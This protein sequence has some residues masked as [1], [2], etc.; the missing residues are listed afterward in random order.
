[1]RLCPDHAES[2][3]SNSQR[4]HLG[5][6]KISKSHFENILYTWAF[7]APFQ[8]N[9]WH[10]PSVSIAKGTP[11]PQCKIMVKAASFPWLLPYTWILSFPQGEETKSGLKQR[12]ILTGNFQVDC[13]KLKTRRGFLVYHFR[14]SKQIHIIT[15]KKLCYTIK[16]GRR[17]N[18]ARTD[19]VNETLQATL[20]QYYQ[21]KVWDVLIL[22]LHKD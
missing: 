16:C 2:N 11:Y 20:N 13:I 5:Q 3:H 14:E 7:V 15:H 6:T 12:S 18:W 10:D 17:G 21:F 1:M 19:W 4:K 22:S 8:L 9:V